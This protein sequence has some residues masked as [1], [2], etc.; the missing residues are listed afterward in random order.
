MGVDFFPCDDCGESI[1]DCGSYWRCQEGCGARLCDDC[2][3]KHKVWDDLDDDG[4][5]INPCPYCKREA[6]TDSQL[7]QF[8]LKKLGV[9]QEALLKEYQAEGKEKKST[10]KRKQKS[11]DSD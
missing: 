4:N 11:G 6:A 1:C 3:D 10:R 7:L 8:A 5:E 9:T 2:A